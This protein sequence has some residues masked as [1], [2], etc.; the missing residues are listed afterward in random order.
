MGQLL[1][2]AAGAAVAP[3]GYASIGWAIGSFIGGQLFGPKPEDVVREGPR[4]SDLRVQSSAY[5]RMIPIVF[6]T[7]RLTG[8][9]IWSRPIEETITTTSEEQGGK[10]GGGQTVTTTTYTYTIDFAVALCEGPIIGIRRI[11]ANGD[12]IYD[13]GASASVESHVAS[14]GIAAAMRVYTGS[15]TQE[16]DELIVAYEG[17]GNAPAYRDTAYVVFDDFALGAYNNSLPQLD[18]E[19]VVAGTSAASMAAVGPSSGFVI[20]RGSFRPDG[21]F[22]TS[23]YTTLASTSPAMALVDPYSWTVVKQFPYPWP[24]DASGAT[25]IDR[26]ASNAAGDVLMGAFG[27]GIYIWREGSVPVAIAPFYGAGTMS[28]MNIRGPIVEADGTFWFGADIDNTG[29]PAKHS[30]LR[31]DP[32]SLVPVLVYDFGA[33]GSVI[34][35]EIADDD[36]VYVTLGDLRVERLTRDGTRLGSLD[37][38]GASGFANLAI[39]GDGSV[40][41]SIDSMSDIYRCA[42][43]LSGYTVI[44]PPAITPASGRYNYIARDWLTGDVLFSWFGKLHRFSAD[45]TYVN[46]VESWGTGGAQYNYLMTSRYVPEAVLVLNEAA[47]SDMVPAYILKRGVVTPGATVLSDVVESI[48]ERCGLDS[49]DLSLSALTDEVAGFVIA[50]RGAARSALE[51]LSAAYNFDIVESDDVLKGVKRGAASAVTIPETDLAVRRDGEQM[52]QAVTE[53]RTADLELP[54]EVA[55]VYLDSAAN[56]QQGVQYA[57]RLA[58]ASSSV[59]V[60]TVEMPLVLTADEAVQ[61]ADRILHETWASRREVTFTTGPKYAFREPTDVVTLEDGDASCTVRITSQQRDGVIVGFTGVTTDATV[62]TQA[63]TGSAL[64]TPTAAVGVASPTNLQILDIPMLRDSDDDAGLYVAARGYLSA[65]DGAELWDGGSPDGLSRTA[66]AFLSPCTIGNAAS[67]LGS[68]AGGNVVDELSTVDVLVPGQTLVS[69]T[70]AELLSGEN[71]A[72][73]GDELIGYGTATLITTGKY[74]LSSLL[75]ARRGTAAAM[76]T[77]V[78]GERFVLLDSSTIRRLELE[79]SSIGVAR[80]YKAPAFGTRLAQAAA[81]PFTST[82]ASLEP[83][84]PVHLGGGRDASGNVAISWVRSTR[85]N[86]EWRDRA[87]AALGESSEQYQVEVWDS[88]YATLK[89]T[90]PTSTTYYTTPA[91]TYSAADQT[92]DFGGTQST[93][94]VRVYQISESVGRGTKLEGVV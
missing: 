23:Y 74:R 46:A 5:G 8:N 73:L 21:L 91:A 14:N 4:L 18:F 89:R 72:L 2:A 68:F 56:Y 25:L 60:R 13:V 24:G 9:V 87:D 1:L 49:A 75:R 54:L 66:V 28:G 61:I 43:D 33:A 55:I 17:A 50:N 53:K 83:L 84:A 22:I 71:A 12:L 57:R 69:V 77:H 67:A 39:A 88:G 32:D 42:A 51:V 37:L 7:V 63:R 44:T 52:P 6:G 10:G 11:W 80:Y 70:R 58:D 41:V 47:A 15:T 36:T 45:G 78:S 93:V 92:T 48:V 19:V 76:S 38:P 16:P 62:Y 31:L 64:P 40:W 85:F 26:V 79:V 27:G 81:L 3:T 90:L 86:P 82:G 30:V 35:I 65:W 94:Y 20:S 59:D 34:A 29:G